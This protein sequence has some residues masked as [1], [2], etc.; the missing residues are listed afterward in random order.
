MDV[1]FLSN[2]SPKNI[3]L[4]YH[5][6]RAKLPQNDKRKK[7]EGVNENRENWFGKK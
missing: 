6:K 4:R 1:V 3:G 7:Q 2:L 5:D